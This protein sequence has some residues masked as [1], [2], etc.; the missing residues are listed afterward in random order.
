[1]KWLNDIKDSASA[2][3]EWARLL[4]IVEYRASVEADNVCGWAHFADVES[5]HA[6]WPH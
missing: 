4:A 3:E 2:F 5:V 1:M 6:G